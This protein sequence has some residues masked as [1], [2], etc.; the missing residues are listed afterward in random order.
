[1]NDT[2]SIAYI[3]RLM[4]F[5]GVRQTKEFEAPNDQTAWREANDGIDPL[6]GLWV[7][8]VR[9]RDP[10]QSLDLQWSGASDP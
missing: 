3:A 6:T 9:K 2:D 5:D 8:V 4:R 10:Q 1:M 7:E